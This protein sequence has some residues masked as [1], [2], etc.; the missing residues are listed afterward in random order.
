MSHAATENRKF[1]IVDFS[2]RFCTTAA[3]QE[4]SHRRSRF[5]NCASQGSPPGGHGRPSP[6]AVA[7]FRDT[8]SLR[9]CSCLFCK[10]GQCGPSRKKWTALQLLPCRPDSRGA[11]AQTQP[12]D[13]SCSSGWSFRDAMIAP[14]ASS[15]PP[16]AAGRGLGGATAL[17][18][19]SLLE[20]SDPTTRKKSI[21]C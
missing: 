5:R 21:I 3:V 17:V 1:D 16:R 15:S 4:K 6:E 10:R 13:T 11:S 7:L 18:M 20:A 8:A 14:S 2:G 9:V 12:C 19:W